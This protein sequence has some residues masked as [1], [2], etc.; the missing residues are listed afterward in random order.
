MDGNAIGRWKLVFLFSNAINDQYGA[1]S[2]TNRLNHIVCIAL[3]FT[4]SVSKEFFIQST[5]IHRIPNECKLTVTIMPNVKINCP[6]ISK[7]ND[8]MYRISYKH[9]LGDY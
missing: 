4:I 8:K 7:T 1:Y 3:L 5:Y 6:I 9:F 2:Y